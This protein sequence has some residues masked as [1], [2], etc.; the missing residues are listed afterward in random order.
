MFKNKKLQIGTWVAQD[1]KSYEYK[2]S[3]EYF[4]WL[5]YG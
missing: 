2:K 1:D 4:V 5:D 3:N